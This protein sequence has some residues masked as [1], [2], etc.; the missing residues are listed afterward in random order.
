MW[1]KIITIGIG[2][3]IGANARYWMSYGIGSHQFPWATLM[4]NLIGCFGLAVFSTFVLERI[5]LS[6]QH[7]LLI[8][9]GFFGAFTTFSTLNMEALNLVLDGKIADRKSTRLN[10]SHQL[11]SY[12]V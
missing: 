9:T 8:A 2:G 3:F 4:V 11:N 5:T 6:E 7:R 1:L 12:A 10:S